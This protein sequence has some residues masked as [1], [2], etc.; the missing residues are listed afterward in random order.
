MI[1]AGLLGGGA[2]FTGG[3]NSALTV[4]KSTFTANVV[5]SGKGPNIFVYG[6]LNVDCSLGGNSFTEGEEQIVTFDFVSLRT[7]FC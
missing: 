2:I 1:Q 7:S 4:S 5:T 6:N 3:P